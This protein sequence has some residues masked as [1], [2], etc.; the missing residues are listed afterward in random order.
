MKKT[1]FNL[2]LAAFLTAG[3]MMFSSCSQ[4]ELLTEES[5]KEEKIPYL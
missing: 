4:D 5:V 3:V 2:G 1:Y